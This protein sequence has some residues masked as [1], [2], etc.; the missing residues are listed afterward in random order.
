MSRKKYISKKA[1]I[2][3]ITECGG[4]ISLVANKLGCSRKN[5]YDRVNNDEDIKAALEDIVNRTGD[6][7]ENII[8]N[9]M[10]TGV[11][12]RPVKNEKSGETEMKPFYI[13]VKDQVKAAQWYAERKLKNRGYTTRHEHTGKDGEEL[14]SAVLVVNGKAKNAPVTDEQDIIED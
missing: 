10:T 7:A 6:A 11:V 12:Y 2:D 4:V 14:K 5:I 13:E 1:I 8:L 9:A 3:A